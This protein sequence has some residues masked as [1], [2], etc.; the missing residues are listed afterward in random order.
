MFDLK[1]R[2]RAILVLSDGTVHRG[3]RIGAD[4]ESFGEVCFHTGMAG[5]QELLTDPSNAGQIV[6]MTYP[7]VGN[8][9]VNP[10][11][12]ESGATHLGGL[13]VRESSRAASNWRCTGD[14]EGFLRENGVVGLEGV[15]TR[16]L[17]RRLRDRGA[18]EGVISSTDLDPDSLL[19]K[20]RRPPGPA[21]EDLVATVTADAPYAMENGAMGE[22]GF[23]VV[24]FDFGVRRGI[25]RRLA[26]MGC[27]VTVVPASTTAD[28]ALAFSP[29]G[30]LL[31]NGPGDPAVVGYAVEAAGGLLGRKPLFGIGLGHQVLALALGAR[32][33]KLK[34]GHRGVNQPVMFARAG[35][36]EITAQNHGYA[37]D[38]DSLA[39]CRFGPVEQTH[40]SLNDSTCEGIRCPDVGAFS[41]QFHPEAS[42]GPHDSR[43]L[44]DLFLEMMREWR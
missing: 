13:V 28:E 2:P 41:V 17:S 31:S 4:G 7:L 27:R 12:F 37:V 35:K 40:W 42:P 24:A 33:Y 39:G 21:G 14:L 34:H 25:L 43:H 11:D 38:A 23:H 16:A 9:G 8:Y 29:D 26:S 1:N 36:V 30:V 18:M 6:S 10:E 5:Y 3:F 19:E 15:D 20:L 32:T 44:F 22:P